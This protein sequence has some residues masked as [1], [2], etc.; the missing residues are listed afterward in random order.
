MKHNVFNKRWLA[1]FVVCKS[2]ES[3]SCR[4]RSWNGE[5]L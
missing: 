5:R 4:P 2:T 1:S 3:S